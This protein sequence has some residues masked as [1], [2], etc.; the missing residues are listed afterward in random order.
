ML[1]YREK[2]LKDSDCKKNNFSQN[3]IKSR[4]SIQN[5]KALSDEMKVKKIT[6]LNAIH[7]SCPV[8]NFNYM[9]ENLNI[10]EKLNNVNVC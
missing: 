10:D 8:E 9:F 1:K 3:T 6:N 2:T 4:L 5:K 7:K